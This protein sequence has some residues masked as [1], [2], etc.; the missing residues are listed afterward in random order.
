MSDDEFQQSD[1]DAGKVWHRKHSEHV[2]SLLSSRDDLDYS[3][4]P[5]GSDVLHPELWKGAHW[6]WFVAKY[7]RNLG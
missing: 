7:M 2:R 6:R 4:P 3:Y 5:S 1:I